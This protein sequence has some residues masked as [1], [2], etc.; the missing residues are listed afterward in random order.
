MQFPRPILAPLARFELACFQLAFSYLEGRRLTR[1][2]YWYIAQSTHLG[3]P[4]DM[5]NSVWHPVTESNSCQRTSK[6]H[7]RVRRTG[8]K[9][10]VL[11]DRRSKTSSMANHLDYTQ[12]CFTPRWVIEENTKL[13]LILYETSLQINF[14]PMLQYHAVLQFLSVGWVD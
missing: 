1:A 4:S 9:I 5:C 10:C 13:A 11:H 14:T 6:A 8:H 7:H 12:M 2:K 3:W